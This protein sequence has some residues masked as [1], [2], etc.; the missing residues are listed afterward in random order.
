MRKKALPLPS[1]AQLGQNQG[2][3]QHLQ[4]AMGKGANSYEEARKLRVEENLK[5]L[6]CLGISKISKSLQEVAKS[7]KAIMKCHSSPRSKKSFQMIEVRRSGRARNPV[8]SYVDGYQDDD[9]DR[10]RFRKRILSTREYNGRIISYEEQV[11]AIER[12]EKL[13]D[14]LDSNNPSFVKPMVRSHVSSCF[15]LGLPTKFCKEHLPERDLTL[16]LEDEKGVE[17]DAVYIGSRAGLSGGWRGFSLDHGLE[18]GDALVFE[19]TEPDRFKV[20]II[21]AIE[22]QSSQEN[23]IETTDDADTDGMS[24]PTKKTRS[25]EK[26][27][28]EPES[29]KPLTKQAKRKAK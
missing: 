19:L 11:R 13:Q 6:E 3:A 23:N 4:R 28:E 5:Q 21:K 29:R 20:H 2:R 12:A 27:K 9:I 7:E 24:R 18:N 14:V 26:K 1:R 22:E 25:S 10:R 16:V 17:Y 15:W 8:S